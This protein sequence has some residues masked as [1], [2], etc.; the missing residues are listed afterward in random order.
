M[1]KVI[2]RAREGRKI[3]RKVEVQDVFNLSMAAEVEASVKKSGW[4]P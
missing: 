1:K 3:E 4:K 2:E